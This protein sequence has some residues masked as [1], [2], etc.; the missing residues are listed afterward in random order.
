MELSIVIGLLIV[1]VAMSLAVFE[2]A[3]TNL[4]RE[5]SRSA[6]NDQLR[7]AVESVD[8][9]VRSGNVLYDPASENYHAGC[10]AVEL[11]TCGDIQPGMSLRIYTQ[12]NFVTRG[13]ATCV[14]WRIT[15]GG[16]LQRRSWLSAV[17]PAASSWQI[18][19]Y[20]ITNRTDGVNAFALSSST[21][22]DMI[23][24]D[25]RA[26]DDPSGKNGSTVEV[27]DSVTGRNT[28]LGPAT[29]P[30]GSVTPDPTIPFSPG[31]Y[32]IPSY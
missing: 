28:E 27:T 23:N 22:A 17:T 5:T 10:S 30:C 21:R 6:S 31:I 1:V 20:H 24:V 3:E 13:G 29:Q 32:P 7:Q 11:P 12:S 8:R 19:A 26:N 25:L 4:G 14:Q 15:S 18:V 2:G 16:E 9:D